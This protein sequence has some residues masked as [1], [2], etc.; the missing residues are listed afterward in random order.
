MLGGRGVLNQPVPTGPVQT[1]HLAVIM[2]VKIR[3]ALIT[4]VDILVSSVA[5]CSQC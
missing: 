1:V 5:R 4:N 3:C 2:S